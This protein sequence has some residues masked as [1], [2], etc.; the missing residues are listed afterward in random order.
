F[1]R[2]VDG[3][4]WL[5]V[6]DDPVAFA[7]AEVRAITTFNGGLV[8]VGVVGTVQDHTGAVAWTSPDGLAWTRIDAPAF[9]DGIAVSVAPAPFGGLVAVGSTVDRKVAVAWI[10]PD[11]KTWT[12]APDEP[13][14]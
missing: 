10:S 11:G 8:A 1:W 13:S 9:D 12:R 7:N 4:T 3:S 2:S 14:R 5:P 6:A